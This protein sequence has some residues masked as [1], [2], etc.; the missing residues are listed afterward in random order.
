MVKSDPDGAE[1]YVTS[2]V[3]D[4]YAGRIELQ[5]LLLSKGLSR[6]PDDYTN[7][8]THAK[9]VKR[10]RKRD[11]GTAPRLGDRVMY[12]M[13]DDID[14]KKRSEWSECP[15]YV[16]EHSIPINIDYYAEHLEKPLSRLLTPVIGEKRVH[17]IFHG[18]H[19]F[20]RK[21][22]IPTLHRPNTLLS[23]VVKQGVPCC[24]CRAVVPVSEHSPYCSVC[25]RDEKKKELI[26]RRKQEEL[27][28][29]QAQLA[30]VETTCR[31]CQDIGPDEPIEC[32]A[33]DCTTLYTRHYRTK[34]VA[35][36]QAVINDW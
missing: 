5:K 6:E 3:T 14:S 8:Q 25:R 7:T 33:K 12:V 1:R 28:A 22:D 16:L 26:R 32:M 11:P 35:K 30:E 27:A 13:V 10:M 21:H 34:A 2:V 31:K 29:A 17:R 19:T 9:L 24:V 18:T 36:A 15:L 20:V 23:F 4:L